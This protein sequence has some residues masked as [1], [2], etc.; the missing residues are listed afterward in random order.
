MKTWMMTFLMNKKSTQFQPLKTQSIMSRVKDN[1]ISKII[2]L[3]R[4]LF[5]FLLI[6]WNMSMK[7]ILSFS[8][9][10]SSKLW[11]KQNSSTT[12]L[13][14]LF[15]ICTLPWMMNLASKLLKKFISWSKEKVTLISFCKVL[16]CF[17]N[18]YKKMK[19]WSKLARRAFSIACPISFLN[20]L[21]KK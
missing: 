16:N 13:W 17:T 12:W 6:N 20:W 9:K 8:K 15:P 10:I 7:V 11:T 14:V 3:F 21:M 18:L 1:F 2:W 5:C 19:F 4:K